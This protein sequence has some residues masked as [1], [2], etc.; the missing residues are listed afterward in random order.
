MRRP[1]KSHITMYNTKGTHVNLE[2]EKWNENRKNSK[3][4]NHPALHQDIGKFK[5]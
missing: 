2:T 4:K 3:R 5:T 1:S